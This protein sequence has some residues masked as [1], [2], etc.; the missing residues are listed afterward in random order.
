MVFRSHCA[1]MTTPEKMLAAD[2]RRMACVIPVGWR[3]A[4]LMLAMVLVF[5]ILICVFVLDAL[6]HDMPR[7]RSGMR[8]LMH[9]VAHLFLFH[10]HTAPMPKLRTAKSAA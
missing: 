10:R 2:L 8:K 7:L 4:V 3:A 6:T 1:A 9:A 5:P